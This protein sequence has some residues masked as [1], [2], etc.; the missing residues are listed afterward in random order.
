[1]ADQAAALRSKAEACR[2]L[3]DM[4]DDP[5]QKSLWSERADNWD[6]LAK[7]A[8]QAAR[9]KPRGSQ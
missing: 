8:E 7:Q 4:A 3:A 9:R 5:L 1:M 2:R 6:A